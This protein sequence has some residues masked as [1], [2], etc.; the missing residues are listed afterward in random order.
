MIRELV[1][2]GFRLSGERDP[3]LVHGLAWAVVEGLLAAAPY[4]LLYLLLR[5]VFGGTATPGTALAIGLALA[6]CVALRIAAARVGMPLVFGG[7]YAM[8]GQAR[9]R[10]ADHLRRLPMGWFARQ[11]GGDL[12]AR[13]TSDLELVENL[14]S[15]FLGIFVSGLAMPAFLALFLFWLDWRLALV[16]LAG[17]PLALLALAWTQRAAAHSGARLVAASAAAQSALLEYVQ[18]IGVIRGFGRFGEA[19]RRLEAALDEHH[20][21]MLAAEIKPAPWLVAYGFLLETG[22]VS[23]VLAGSW[24]LAAGTLAPQVL[25]AFLVLA[26]PVYRQLFEVGLSTVLLRFARRAL[27]RIEQVLAQPALPEPA[28]PRVPQGY[29]ITFEDARFAYDGAPVLD[30][31]SCEIPANGLTAVVGPSGAGKSTLVH[32]IARLWDVQ[33]GSIRL[34]GADLR[35]IGTDALHRHVAMVFQDVL[36]FSGTVLDNLRIGRPGA[37]REQAIEAARRAQAHGFIMALPQGYD[38]VLDEGGASLSGGERQRISIA[39]ALLKDAPVLL[40]DEATA[41]VDPSAEAEIQR[42]IT[43]LAKGRTVVA[44]AHRLAS[45][46]HADRI[47]VLDQGKLVEQGRHADLIERGGLYA[48][49]WA[50]QQQAR[51]WELT[52]SNRKGD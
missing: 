18:G 27:A 17:I 1:Q 37:S 40:L 28:Q 15:H 48:R 45:V 11:R 49:L 36:L 5:A 39:R 43:E 12:G 24:W 8:M 3:R 6:A 32:L 25:V 9:L 35:E 20:A 10:V 13:L 30:G 16:M 2:A 42:A 26:L 34:G 19:F 38:T 50:A 44:I 21:A 41:S 47:L 22:Y 7:A 29:A 52:I 14:W 23:L 51:D 46:R 33:G 31:M 4:P